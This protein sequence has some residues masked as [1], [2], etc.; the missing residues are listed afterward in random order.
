M[1]PMSPQQIWI[2]K[3]L[4]SDS[5]DPAGPY[6]FMKLKVKRK[7]KIKRK[8][9]KIQDTEPCKKVVDYLDNFC[10][11]YRGEDDFNP[12]PCKCKKVDIQVKK[13]Q[14]SEK[15]ESLANCLDNVFMN[16]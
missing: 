7:F 1:L 8:E 15:N 9:T 13:I 16:M 11:C 4:E 5:D 6:P 12:L 3:V 10:Y 14:V 2:S